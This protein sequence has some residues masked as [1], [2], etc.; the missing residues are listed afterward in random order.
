MTQSADRERLKELAKQVNEGVIVEIGSKNG[1]SAR[2]MALFAKVPVY[3]ID[4]WDLTFL[5]DRRPKI[6][7]HDDKDFLKMTEG[8]NVIPIKGISSEIAKAWNRPIG[9]LF[10]DGD[11]TYKGCM[12]DYEGFA[13]HINPGGFLVFHDYEPKFKDVV[14]AVN[15]IK[16]LSIWTDWELDCTTISARR[17][18]G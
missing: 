8:L 17:T 13:H 15:E 9:L 16:Q 14:K 1:L 18:G 12:A 5:G 4:M 3:C 2:A 11:H 6:H 10:I 7:L